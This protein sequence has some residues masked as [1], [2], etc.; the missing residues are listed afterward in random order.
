[1]SDTQPGPATGEAGASP[2]GQAK[3]RRWIEALATDMGLGRVRGGDAKRRA[4]DLSIDLDAVDVPTRRAVLTEHFDALERRGELVEDEPHET[5]AEQEET[6]G[7]EAEMDVDADPGLVALDPQQRRKVKVIRG[8]R[9]RRAPDEPDGGDAMEGV[10]GGGAIDEFDRAKQDRRT[11]RKRE[12]RPGE[13]PG[14]LPPVE[15]TLIH[16]DAPSTVNVTR[17]VK[18]RV[19]T[20]WT[21]LA[22][23]YQAKDRK[24]KTVATKTNAVPE[25]GYMQQT[26]FAAEAYRGKG[27]ELIE[28]DLFEF[29]EDEAAASAEK[30]RNLGWFRHP[31]LNGPHT[32]A[33]TALT[34][35]MKAR[36]EAVGRDPQ[37]LR[38]QLDEMLAC[39]HIA[40]PEQVRE[41]LMEEEPGL[42]AEGCSAERPAF[43][44]GADRGRKARVARYANTYAEYFNQIETL[45][46]ELSSEGAPT[47]MEPD[48]IEAALDRA[49]ELLNLHPYQSYGW[50]ADDV[51]ALHEI[52]GKGE[53][54][55]RRRLFDAPKGAEENTTERRTAGMAGLVDGM[56]PDRLFKN[57]DRYRG[58]LIKRI[59]FLVG[60]EPDG[61]MWEGLS[62]WDVDELYDL[63]LDQKVRGMVEK[64]EA[65]AAKARKV[66]T[67]VWRE[68]E[69]DSE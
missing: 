6:G 28:Q 19:A 32:V 43:A 30:D 45:V 58:F 5:P 46:A 42:Y 37:A 54:A 36:R 48:R 22:E 31:G 56:D 27:G 17:G 2:P 44:E 49:E 68:D 15:A 24:T 66:E 11:A 25:K 1:M 14:E 51:I 33:F 62:D 18:G 57:P 3:K 53:A 61:A 64:A 7:S 29:P 69:E 35:A 8:M 23:A 10:D 9:L 67:T 39:G 4:L 16:R 52:A 47:A 12:A 26:R 21:M 63:V 50:R 60:V 59:E 13:V 55:Y 34:S 40:A 38:R 65:K 41:I 20:A